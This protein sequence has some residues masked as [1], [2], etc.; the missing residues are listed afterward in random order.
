MG[1]AVGSAEWIGPEVVGGEVAGVD[2]DSGDLGV[3][4]DWRLAGSV[5]WVSPGPKAGYRL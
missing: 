4:I 2:A 1:A 3:A 5:G